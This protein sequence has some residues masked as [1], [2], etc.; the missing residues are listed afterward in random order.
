MPDDSPKRTGSVADQAYETIRADI[1]SGAL[2][3]RGRLTETTLAE[4]FGIS[5]TPVREAVKRLILEGL[6][7][8]ESGPGLR[9]AS[10]DPDEI[11]QIF[12]IRLLLECYAARRAA[13][14]ASERHVETLQRLAETMSAHVPP[15]GAAHY[16]I[17]SDANAEFHRTIVEAARSPR[18]AMILSVTT[19]L[20]L[21]LRTYRMYSEKDIARS[22]RHHHE[23]ADA[24]AARAPDWAAAAMASHLH[25][26]AAISRDQRGEQG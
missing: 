23:I 9:V 7:T 10:L 20:A 3:T 1:I 17:I 6:L 5:R 8:R 12:Q 19:D 25:A 15:Q 16:R 18:I 13:S 14:F 26:A 11:D 22:S 2:P 24:I 21:V 4:R